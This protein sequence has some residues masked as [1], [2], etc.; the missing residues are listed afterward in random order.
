MTTPT[1]TKQKPAEWIYRPAMYA[2]IIFNDRRKRTFYS[3]ELVNS[4]DQIAN[5]Y[6]RVEIDFQ[7]GFDGLVKMI[8][9]YKGMYQ[10]ARIYGLH[11]SAMKVGAVLREYDA[12]GVYEDKIKVS[13]NDEEKWIRQ[14]EI[15]K[16]MIADNMNQY[17]TFAHFTS[18]KHVIT[19]KEGVYIEVQKY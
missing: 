13:F 4:L 8:N 7:K 9:K 11:N 10:I 15:Q 19:K 14:K 5:G 2:W 18:K 12:D 3:Y 16:R 17:N 1:Q 6:E